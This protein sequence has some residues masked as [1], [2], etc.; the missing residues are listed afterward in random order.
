MTI[1]QLEE[2]VQRLHVAFLNSA[3]KTGTK[4]KNVLLPPS[5][6]GVIETF[7]SDNGVHLPESYR[8]FLL[9]HNGWKNFENNSILTG[10][11]G[12][13]TEQALKDFRKRDAEFVREWTAAGHSTDEAFVTEYESQSGEGDTLSEAKLYLP[14]LIK[15]GTNLTH[16]LYAFNPR[17]IDQ[18]G[19]PEVLIIGFTS[20][21]Y[22]RNANFFDFLTRTLAGYTARGY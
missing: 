6:V 9:L 10:A 16:T 4:T 14:S 2:L 19:E 3:K 1:T 5:S 7:Q 17:R 8:Q 18:A 13:H 20:K 11:D 15:F 22:R 21:I 12:P